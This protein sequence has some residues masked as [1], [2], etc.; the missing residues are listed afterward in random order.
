MKG[1]N[2]I[3]TGTGCCEIG[4]NGDSSWSEAFDS[5]SGNNGLSDLDGQDVRS[6]PYIKKVN[7]SI[8]RME[9][10]EQNLRRGY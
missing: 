5:N 4:L 1:F 7:V 10:G 6:G 9:L 8:D 3:H 2:L